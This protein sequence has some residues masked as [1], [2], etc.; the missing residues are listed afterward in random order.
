M[1]CVFLMESRDLRKLILRTWSLARLPSLEDII[2]ERS[3]W[4]GLLVVVQEIET[5]TMRVVIAFLKLVR[6]PHFLALI[7]ILVVDANFCLLLE[8]D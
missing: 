2:V 8:E 3:D 4:E 6:L 1:R 5:D 7:P